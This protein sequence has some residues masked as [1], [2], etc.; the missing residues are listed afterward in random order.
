MIVNP[1]QV[2]ANLPK[3]P[4]ETYGNPISSLTSKFGSATSQI[5]SITS[6]IA[7]TLSSATSSIGSSL[8]SVTSSVASSATHTHH[9]SATSV[10][11][12]PT[13]LPGNN[14]IYEQAGDAGQRTL[15]YVSY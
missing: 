14:A 6:G 2:M 1:A 15:W 9:H 8:S 12:I 10:A 11:P 5:P 13:V 3:L 7:S 4:S